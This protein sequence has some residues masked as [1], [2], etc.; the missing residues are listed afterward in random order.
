MPLMDEFR[1]Q[2]EAIK[3]K[4]FKEKFSYYW[5][6][7]RVHFFAV[8][9]TL[10]F[11]SF[12]IHDIVT[13]KDYAFYA[14]FVNSVMSQDDAAFMDEFS[15]YME[16]NTDKYQTMVDSSLRIS[17]TFDEITMASQQKIMAIIAAQEVDTML[18]VPNIFADYADNHTFHDLRTVLTAEQLE[19]YQDQFFYMDDIEVEE[20]PMDEML[21]QAE[22]EDT[23]DYLTTRTDPSSM[24][25][26]TPVG[27]FLDGEAIVKLQEWGYYGEDSHPVFGIPSNTNNI[28]NALKFL[29]WL[30]LNE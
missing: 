11:G 19:K 25:N 4:P 2:R 5:G 28:E 22:L 10:V 29:D 12:F 14:I 6:Y 18:S 15:E 23:E 30:Y 17:E 21:A 16:L 9:F 1:E 24:E 7:Y 20:L 3:N 26:P 27:I 13:A 8:V